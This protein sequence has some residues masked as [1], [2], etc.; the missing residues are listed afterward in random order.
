MFVMMTLDGIL[1]LGLLVAHEEDPSCIKVNTQSVVTECRYCQH[2]NS[3][4]LQLR[5]H[6]KSDYH[7]IPVEINA[8]T[9]ITVDAA[10][11]ACL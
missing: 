8:Y 2:C 11:L 3:I 5:D 6:F 7:A 10:L 1:G 9:N 4:Q